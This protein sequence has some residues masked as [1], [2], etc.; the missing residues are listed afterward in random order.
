MSDNVNVMKVNSLWEKFQKY[1]P[2]IALIIPLV[3][4][5]FSFIVNL[6]IF[7]KEKS[8]LLYFRIDENYLILNWRLS[9]YKFIVT[10]VLGICYWLYTVLSVRV[11][12]KK[13]MLGILLYFIIFPFLFVSF[14]LYK[15]AG[16]KSLF[17]FLV[18]VGCSTFFIV[19]IHYP[20][21]YV[22][23]YCIAKDIHADILVEKK[24]LKREK[25]N[26]RKLNNTKIDY[27][28]FSISILFGL[29]LFYIVIFSVQEYNSAKMQKE[30]C[31]ININNK[32][33]AVIS[34]EGKEAIAE[35]C[36]INNDTNTMTID[37]DIIM[38]VN[39]ENLEQE[40]RIFDKV[41]LK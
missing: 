27:F 39:T 32:T 14:Y 34:N 3:I 4:S 35:S 13:D 22:F 30:F 37:T 20:F 5:V 12:L 33:Y 1:T 23:G 2:Q 31:I 41:K 38:I 15:V 16:V 19:I 10:G 8:Y 24:T 26:K 28:I 11:F 18:L 6:I 9:L 7:Y 25:K 36:K 40:R 17:D 21:T 29:L